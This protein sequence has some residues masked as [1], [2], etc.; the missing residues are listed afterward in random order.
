MG[1]LKEPNSMEECAYF[2][3]RKTKNAVIRK[4]I[5]LEST[6]PYKTHLYERSS[7]CFTLSLLRIGL[8]SNGVTKSSINHFTNVHTFVAISNH[9]AIPTTFLSQYNVVGIAV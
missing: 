9:T 2:T 6:L 7:I 8:R 4:S 1:K 5:K 3:N